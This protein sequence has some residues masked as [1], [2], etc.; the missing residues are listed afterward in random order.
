MKRRVYTRWSAP[1][2]T[3]PPTASG[4]HVQTPAE[5]PIPGES[6]PPS[7]P[8]TPMSW[9]SLDRPVLTRKPPAQVAS[10]PPSASSECTPVSIRLRRGALKATST[11]PRDGPSHVGNRALNARA[12][13]R[14]MAP[15]PDTTPTGKSCNR[16]ACSGFCGRLVSGAVSVPQASWRLRRRWEDESTEVR[17]RLRGTAYPRVAQA[18]GTLV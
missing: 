8:K 10:S 15:T 11:G 2:D 13:P 14:T 3:R 18:L 16:E 4:A 1:R 17:V 5:R 9:A 12:L 7:Q 6:P